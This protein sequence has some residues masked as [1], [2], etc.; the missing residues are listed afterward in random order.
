MID[1]SINESLGLPKD[2]NLSYKEAIT[3]K[4]RFSD[5]TFG[6]KKPISLISFIYYKDKYGDFLKPKNHFNVIVKAMFDNLKSGDRFSLL[7]YFNS[8]EK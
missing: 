3:I 5:A 4:G 8:E 1:Q 6:S 7:K 2:Y